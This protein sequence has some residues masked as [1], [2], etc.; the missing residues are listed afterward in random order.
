[1]SEKSFIFDMHLD[2]AMN[3]LVYNRD[4]RWSLERIRR[5][6][7]ITFLAPDRKD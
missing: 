5:W 1:M 6:E 4:I 2:L 7:H 3:A